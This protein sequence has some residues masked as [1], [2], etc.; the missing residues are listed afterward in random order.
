MAKK[1]FRMGTLL[2]YYY[3]CKR[4]VWLMAHSIV[5]D[6][7]DENIAMGRWIEQRSYKRA[8]KDI[9]ID[10][11]KFDIIKTHEGEV[12]IEEVKKSSHYLKSATMQL[13]YY[14]SILKEK[15]IRAKGI[16]RI[17]KEKKTYKVIL[18]PQLEAELTRAIKDIERIVS[19]ERP[20]TAVKIKFCKSCAYAQ[21]CWA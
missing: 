13:A 8:K 17:P 9:N 21:M 11:V 3:I 6:Q 19:M 1:L 18:N 7:D 5:P 16:I 15:G 10:S 14:L 4:E 12:V 2:W 20:P